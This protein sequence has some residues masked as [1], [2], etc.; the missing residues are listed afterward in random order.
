MPRR[1]DLSTVLIIGSGPITI[2]QACEFDYAGVQACE[3]LQACGYRVI[4]LNS[5]PATIMTDPG[6]AHRTYIEPII[7]ATL[8]AI[9]AQEQPDAILPTMGGQTALNI[10]M[11]LFRTGDLQNCEI[12]GTPP[13]AIEKAE[14]RCLFRKTIL[15]LGFECLN[16]VEADS[17]EAAQEALRL[18]PLP[19]VIRPSFT[20]GGVGG[21]IAHSNDE[22]HSIVS[23]AL[24]L[25]PTHR[26]LVEE[27]IAGWKE[28]EL[29]V[30]RDAHDQCLAVCSMENVDPMGVHTGDSIVVAPALTLTDKELQ[31]MRRMAFAIIRA[32]GI[33]GGA[34][35]Q[36]AIHPQSGRI[37]VIEMNPRVSRSS[38]LASKATGFPI[39]AISAQ[40]AVGMT[41]EECVC[42]RGLPLEPTIDYIVTKLPRFD[43]Q[44][45][46]LTTDRLGTFMQ[47]VGETMAIGQ[48]FEES[49]Q[50]AMRSLEIGQYSLR[51]P[52]LHDKTKEEIIAH[53]HSPSSDRLF[54]IAEGF[55]RGLELKQIQAV[56]LW[57]PWFLE[58]IQRL[59]TIEQSLL[60][61]EL[62]ASE[63]QLRFCTSLGFSDA[64]IASSLHINEE[65]VRAARNHFGIHHSFRQI[66][67]WAGERPSTT[68]HFYSTTP[69][70]PGPEIDTTINPVTTP[71][72]LVIGS[73]PNRIA[74]GIEFDYCCVRACQA[75]KALGIETI[76]VN[77]NP[78]TVS[79][80]HSIANRLYIAPLCKEDCLEII[81]HE[82]Q[83]GPLL[84]AYIQFGGQTSLGL[85][86]ALERAG[87][88]LIGI[89]TEAITL[90][91]ARD[92]FRSL[93]HRCS[94]LQ[95]RNQTANSVDE[96]LHLAN[97]EIGFPVIIRPSFVLGG[98][99]MRIF[100]S[101]S[102][103]TQYCESTSFTGTY[104]VLVEEFLRNAREYDI[105]VLSDGENS[106]VAGI[107]EQFEPAGIH[108]G[109]ST[110]LFPPVS[111]SAEMT[112]R[113]HQGADRLSK[114]LH[115]KGL[116][117]LQVAIHNDTIFVLEVNPR[118]SRTVPFLS[119]AQGLPIVEYAIRLSL[120]E[121]LAQVIPPFRSTPSSYAVKAPV[122]SFD[123]FPSISTVLGPTMKSTGESMGRGNSPQEATARAFATHLWHTQKAPHLLLVSHPDR[124]LLFKRLIATGATIST[125]LTYESNPQV[126]T[127]SFEA[128]HKACLE[129]TIDYAFL[130][131]PVPPI[132]QEKIH[133]A[134]HEH[135]IPTF[136]THDHLNG[137]LY[138]SECGEFCKTVHPLQSIARSIDVD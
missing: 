137:W 132:Y 72:V 92:Q 96:L 9:L 75:L 7:P 138:V 26:V 78:E 10:T 50:K 107:A 93:L 74:Q 98:K 55:A 122:F 112:A 30:I 4:L 133:Q 85:A 118:A 35:V 1:D 106:W 68:P 114:A 115:I 15:S 32:I 41:L 59:V 100:T 127:L 130:L 94:L 40:A 11:E 77:C 117:N 108:S 86:H 110:C 126:Q 76:M 46:G 52:S 113:L 128:I 84:G 73:G 105:E 121:P 90:T 124:A 23:R 111:L 57:D 37:V 109:D 104:P 88:P 28:V 3:A 29:E 120:G 39:A 95:P 64:T 45:L 70:F 83:S 31:T 62:L 79:T 19:L 131:D 34:N 119:K 65:G 12:L 17:L 56:T 5:N 13:N 69:L 33:V 66:D 71:K 53:L 48:S 20:L 36:F 43:F 80:D 21:G 44:K 116:F 60:T 8:R 135:G 14:D 58:K 99:G 134:L 63:D 61:P 129:E 47:S 67:G 38:A 42:S 49:L 27:S 51:M 25:S 82:Q 125:N 6:H 102:E 97:H 2:G 101:S 16:A 54:W 123:R 103:L 87:V 22:F 81:Q 91:E 136:T 24:P 18:L 89:S